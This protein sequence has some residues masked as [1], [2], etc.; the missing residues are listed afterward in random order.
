MPPSSRN[1]RL[2]CS[3]VSNAGDAS[4][5]VVRPEYCRT[6]HNRVGA[7]VDRESGIV[8]ILSAVNGN[9]G[10]EPI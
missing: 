7:G 10:V 3:A 1:R 6:G 5:V 2:V 8:A 4:R 9:P